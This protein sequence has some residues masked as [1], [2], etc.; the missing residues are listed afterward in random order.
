MIH[1]SNIDW[2]VPEMVTYEF[3]LQHNKGVRNIIAVHPMNSLP[4][5]KLLAAASA[6]PNQVL[7][8]QSSG[9]L[10]TMETALTV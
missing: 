1:G 10:E 5:D 6:Y 9:C 4:V 3:L 7:H 8:S 2:G